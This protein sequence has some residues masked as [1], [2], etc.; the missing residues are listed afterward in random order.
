MTYTLLVSL[1]ALTW[2]DAACLAARTRPTGRVEFLLT[3]TL[4]WNAMMLLPIYVL[5]L[6][7]RLSSASLAVAATLVSLAAVAL[8]SHGTTI[9][10]AMKSGEAA[11]RRLAALP[12]DALATAWNTRSFALLG[13]TAVL[14]L[15][16]WTAITSY[17]A[18]PW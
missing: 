1:T 2:F 12:F 14:I 3:C 15:V 7:N 16:V 18:P 17:F 6:A 13:I 4:V 10:K 11:L 5:G 8:A 9:G